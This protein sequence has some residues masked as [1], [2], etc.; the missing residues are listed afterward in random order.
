MC[1][2]TITKEADARHH[3]YIR[4]ISKLLSS[5]YLPGTKVRKPNTGD[6]HEI[7][8]IEEWVIRREGVYFVAKEDGKVVWIESYGGFPVSTPYTP[9]EG[10]TTT[11]ESPTKES[12]TK[13]SFQGLKVGSLVRIVGKSSMGNGV[14]IGEIFELEY[15][16]LFQIKGII[17]PI[18]S[19]EPLTP[20]ETEQCHLHKSIK[21]GT[22]VSF[23][24]KEDSGEVREGKIVDEKMTDSGDLLVVY[25]SELGIS[26]V[27][28]RAIKDL[29]IL[30]D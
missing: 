2:T 27:V 24:D 28:R 10:S 11:K 16:P 4:I 25:V 20:E 8:P 26:K 13:E 1:T 30:K 14:K 15:I 9:H 22:R 12:P 3:K 23:I 7:R 21:F 29:T 19:I 6:L 18:S 5:G 17:Y